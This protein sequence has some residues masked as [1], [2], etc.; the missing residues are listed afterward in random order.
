MCN[1]RATRTLS[2]LRASVAWLVGRRDRAANEDFGHSKF[3]TPNPA[4]EDTSC[5]SLPFGDECNEEWEL[6]CV[7]R[8]PLAAATPRGQGR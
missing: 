5:R 3:V 7:L 6:I 4:D 8:A 2:K 1:S